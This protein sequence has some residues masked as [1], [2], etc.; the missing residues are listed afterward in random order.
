MLTE[1][2]VEE[3]HRHR[4]DLMERFH[5]DFNAF[6]TFIKEQEKLSKQQLIQPP[7]PK[8]LSPHGSLQRTRSARRV[9][10]SR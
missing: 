8:P 6:F 4:Q 3:I 5:Y 2:I 9:A 1:P 7:E 10:S